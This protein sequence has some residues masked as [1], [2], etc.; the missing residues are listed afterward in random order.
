MVYRLSFRVNEIA[1]TGRNCLIT[2]ITDIGLQLC[3]VNDKR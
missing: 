2:V 1:N 3:E